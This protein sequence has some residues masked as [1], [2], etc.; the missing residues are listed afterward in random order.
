MGQL[1]A[2]VHRARR[3]HRPTAEEQAGLQLLRY[4]RQPVVGTVAFGRPSFQAGLIG[5]DFP[6]YPAVGAGR[7]VQHQRIFTGLDGA[8]DFSVSGWLTANPVGQRR[9]AADFRGIANVQTGKVGCIRAGCPRLI[10]RR[11]AGLRGGNDQGDIGR[12][13][14]VR[15]RRQNDQHGWGDVRVDACPEDGQGDDACQAQ[16]DAGQDCPADQPPAV[17]FTNSRQIRQ[18]WRGVRLLDGQAVDRAVKRPGWVALAAVRAAKGVGFSH[19]RSFLPGAAR[20]D[21]MGGC[22]GYWIIPTAAS[23]CGSSQLKRYFSNVGNGIQ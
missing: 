19:W 2:L 8:N 15:L 10:E 7:T 14:V 11:Y 16:D 22:E 23:G 9:I 20:I 1:P 18:N 12:R 5:A 13:C 6:P 17:H 21:V 4:G 3:D